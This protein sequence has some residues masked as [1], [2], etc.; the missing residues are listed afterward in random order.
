[1][2]LAVIGWKSLSVANQRGLILTVGF[3]CP[4]AQIIVKKVATFLTFLISLEINKALPVV[5][6]LSLVVN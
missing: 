4:P 5:S 3:Y 6:I 2:Q 1:M